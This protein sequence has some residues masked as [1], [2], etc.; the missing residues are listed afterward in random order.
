[1]ILQSQEVHV[2]ACNT[3]ANGRQRAHAH[4]C[5]WRD[6]RLIVVYVDVDAAAGPRQLSSTQMTK[7]DKSAPALCN[8][9]TNRLPLRRDPQGTL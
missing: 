2:R 5:T 4:M 9:Q 3:N 1:M 8:L 6:L 7:I